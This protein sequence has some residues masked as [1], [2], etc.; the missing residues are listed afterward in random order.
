VSQKPPKIR[1]PPQIFLVFPLGESVSRWGMCV[2]E[3]KFQFFCS[4][5]VFRRW[6]TCIRRGKFEV[7]LSAGQVFCS[8]NTRPRAKIQVFPPRCRFSTQRTCTRTPKFQFHRR[9]ASSERGEHAS[10]PRNPKKFKKIPFFPP[11]N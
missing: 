1:T 11:K 5:S 2:R 10:T 4:A 7:F 9:G 8:V 3:V 6:R